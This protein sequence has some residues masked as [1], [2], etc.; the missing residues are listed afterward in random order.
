MPLPSL[1]A[2]D[3]APLREEVSSVPDVVRRLIITDEASL[4]AAAT[5][6]RRI[7]T[8][9]TTVADLFTPHIARAYDAHR[10]LIADRQRWEAPVVAAETILKHAIAAFTA[11]EEARRLAQARRQAAEAQDARVARLWDEVEELDAA[12][13][14]GEAA[15]LVADLVSAPPLMVVT[16]PPV[17]VDGIHAREVWRFAV[18]DAAAIPREYLAIDHKKLG[19]VVRALKGAA[20]IPGVRV[21]AERTIA[22]SA[23]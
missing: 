19:G 17:T 12:G 23:R 14:H 18:I 5:V 8:L 6:L 22:A 9:R 2:P 3:V 20:Q 21:W 16:P 4:T 7:K 10:A 11:A 1:S 13:Y 15:E